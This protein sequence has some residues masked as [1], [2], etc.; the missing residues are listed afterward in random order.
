MID[1]RD[2]SSDPPSLPSLSHDADQDFFEN[3][4]HLHPELIEIPSGSEDAESIP[5]IIDSDGTFFGLGESADFA[6]D[7]VCMDMEVEDQEDFIE[8][9]SRPRLIPRIAALGLA[10]F[11]SLSVDVLTGFDLLLSEKRK[12]VMDHLRRKRPRSAML[13]PP[14]TMFSQLM[15]TNWARM[16]P[17]VVKHRWREAMTLFKFAIDIA[18]F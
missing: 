2:S 17:H 10:M 4:D 3:L 12:E 18:I 13:S 14:R 16:D 7:C 11:A 8:I 15:N 9:F 6:L 1:I 5:S